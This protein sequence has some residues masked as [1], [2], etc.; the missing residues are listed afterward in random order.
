MKK[1]GPDPPGQTG[2][3]P[4]F[5]NRRI[6]SVKNRAENGPV[7]PEKTGGAGPRPLKDTNGTRGDSHAKLQLHRPNG[8]GGDSGQRPKI[9]SDFDQNFTKTAI[10]WPKVVQSTIRRF[11]KTGISPV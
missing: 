11:G 8:L 4:V 2:E 5:P 6:F 3:N 7:D 10:T 9:G 1:F